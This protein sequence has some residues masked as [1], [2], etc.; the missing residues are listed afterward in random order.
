MKTQE[1]ADDA[2]SEPEIWKKSSG[3]QHA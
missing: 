2:A 1:L 3:E